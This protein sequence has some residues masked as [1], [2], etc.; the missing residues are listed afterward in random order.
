MRQSGSAQSPRW[1]SCPS[2]T[3]IWAGCGCCSARFS[4][5]WRTDSGRCQVQMTT[6]ISP[7]LRIFLPDLHGLRAPAPRGAVDRFHDGQGLDGITG[8][9]ADAG[10]GADGA[11]EVLPLFGQ[12]VQEL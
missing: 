2:T 8:A 11:E 1:L 5:S 9:A 10:A 6:V 12:R 4:K 3:R 7:L